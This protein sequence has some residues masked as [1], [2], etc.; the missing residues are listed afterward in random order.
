MS[1][2]SEDMGQRG[3]GTYYIGPTIFNINNSCMTLENKM[4]L[5]VNENINELCRKDYCTCILIN[6]Y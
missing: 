3:K 4:Q 1:L 5:K 6:I 2:I